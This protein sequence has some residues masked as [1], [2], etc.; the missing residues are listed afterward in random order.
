MKPVNPELVGEIWPSAEPLSKLSHYGSITFSPAGKFEV[1]SLQTF[2]LVYTVGRY[3]IDDTGA[4]KVVF[5]FPMDIG[6]LQTSD[7]AALNYVTAHASNRATLTVDYNASGHMRPRNAALTVFVS[8]GFMT[9]GD[10][11]TIIFGDTSAGS[12]GMQLQTCCESAFEFKVL[13][14]IY[15]T[16]HFVPLPETPAISIVSGSPDHWKA[17]A[18]TL[19]RT[20]EYFSLGLRADDLWGNP[21]DHAQ[22]D[23][24]I[25]TNIP[26]ENLPDTI[27]FPQGRQSLR[28][29]NLVARH[30]G[31][32]RIRIYNA[33]DKHLV[34]AN[35]MVVKNGP[36]SSYWGDLHGQTGETVAINTA[37]EYL[38]FARDLAFLD[39]TS[40][41]GNDFQM[42]TIFWEQLNKLTAEFYQKDRFVTF[43]GY[44]W[45]GNTSIGGDHNVFFRHE[46]RP[47][48]RS[49][50]ALIEDKS[51]IESDALTLHELFEA[52]ADEDCVVYSHVGGRPANIAYAHDP[53]IKTALEIHSAWGTFEWL[54][55]D[56]FALKH[57]CGVVCNSDDHKCRP[58][59]SHPGASEFG[60][61]GGLTC[62]LAPELSRDSIFNCLRRRHH[63]GTS[64]NR[65][66]LDV[67]ARFKKEASVFELDPRVYTVPPRAA[68]EAMM[69]NIIQTHE[70]T[71]DLFVSA[72]AHTPMERIEVFNAKDNIQTLRGFG[73]R[74][75]GNRIRV[76]WSGAKYRGRGRETRWMGKMLLE[77]ARITRFEKINSWNPERLF[78]QRGSNEIVW[79]TI[80]TGNFVGFDVWLDNA[81]SGR[82][83][84][85]TNYVKATLPL[86]DIGM[87]DTVFRADGLERQL[88]VFRMPQIN[89]AYEL[90]DTVTMP[91]RPRGDNPIWVRVTTDDG[92]NAWSSPIYIYREEES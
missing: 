91:L 7:P 84:I 47:I 20:G 23:L 41:Q 31:I 40:H 68:T 77:D 51:D 3:G 87:E 12:P 88:K 10:T 57:R 50:H 49:S 76:V 21:S 89:Q 39:V 86:D 60:A 59:A 38:T 14:D 11:I 72:V 82:M 79:D 58:G 52:L 55:T 56:S 62:F 34:D 85:E 37:R 63:Y 46:D 19:R 18:P 6:G 33:H 5:R 32:H 75:V 15:A 73:T 48:R 42:K 24:R 8:D 78:E 71:V 74:D 9:R 64:G 2:K 92:H 30:E 67:R 69:G 25:E 35:P 53:K 44:E 81:N 22:E 45:S 65:L 26:I 16:G 83:V 17:I 43:P 61:Y 90:Q 4:I 66:L 29:D 13:V 54:L 28:I 1:R 70:E 80:T 36:L 27:P